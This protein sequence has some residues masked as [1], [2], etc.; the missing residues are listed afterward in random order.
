MA[1]C[2]KEREVRDAETIETLAI[3]R[4]I[5]QCIHLGIRHLLIESDCQVVVN[6]IIMEDE[7]L[8]EVGPLIHDI[9]EWMG[10]F[11]SCK[12]QFCH[13]SNNMAAHTPAKYAQ[14]VD[15]CRIW[16]GTDPKILSQIVWFGK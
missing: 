16:F 14:N 11:T 5:Q 9:K 8:A 13:S 1:A 15:E 4:S 3:L 2:M 12:I 6:Q 10:K 7:S